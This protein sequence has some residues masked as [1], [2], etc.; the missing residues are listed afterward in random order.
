MTSLL[1]LVD[2][3][4]VGAALAVAMALLAAMSCITFWQVVTRFVLEAPSTWTE[5]TARSLMIWMVYLGLCVVLRSGSLI[6]VDILMTA[7]PPPRRKALAVLIAGVSLGVLGVL[8]IHGWAMTERAASQ[9]IAGL[10]N[11]FTGGTVSIGLVYA[12][13]PVGAA[14][15]IV[16]VIARLAEELTGRVAVRPG[17]ITHDV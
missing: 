1:R 5:V 8:V 15:S 14:L 17:P 10:E 7:L 6:A 13:V 11:P 12:A 4:V 3:L 16:A 2:R 9:S